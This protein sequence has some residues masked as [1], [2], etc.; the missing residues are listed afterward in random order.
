MSLLMASAGPGWAGLGASSG[1]LSPQCRHGVPSSVILL[2]FLCILTA[3][4]CY[5]DLKSLL[6]GRS[7]EEQSLV[8]ER[9][10]KCNHPSLSVGNKAKLEVRGRGFGGWSDRGP[11]QVA[12]CGCGPWAL[13]LSGCKTLVSV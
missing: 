1:V 4:T 3:P 11:L 13:I 2:P 6:S 5:E 8:V 7:P 9:I 12:Q 10:Q